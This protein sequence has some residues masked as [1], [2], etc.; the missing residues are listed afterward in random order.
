MTSTI[1]LQDICGFVLEASD[2]LPKHII[3]L[4]Y[5]D[6]PY[7]TQSLACLLTDP[8]FEFSAKSGT[9]LG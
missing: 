9:K 4:H 8:A 1:E 7:S 2:L 6:V 5:H 3:V